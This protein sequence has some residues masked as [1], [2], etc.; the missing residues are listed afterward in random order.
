MPSASQSNWFTNTTVQNRSKLPKL[1]A[2]HIIPSHKSSQPN[3]LRK[4]LQGVKALE[5]TKE[6]ILFS[7]GKKICFKTRSANYKAFISRSDFNEIELPDLPENETDLLGTTYLFLNSKKENLEKGA[8]YTGPKISQLVSEGL[9]FSRGQRVLDPSCGSGSLLLA[10]LAAP[11]SLVGIDNDPNAI[12]CATFNYFAK[13]P[14]A[15]SPSLLTCDFFEWSRSNLDEKFDYILANPP[16]GATLDLERFSN[17]VVESGESFSYF[18][19][20]S[21]HHLKPDGVM[22]FLL[23]EAFMNVKRHKDIRSHLIDS[24]NIQRIKKIPGKFSGVMSDIVLVEMSKKRSSTFLFE[25]KE[26]TKVSFETI[27]AL[28]NKIFV[29]LNPNEDKL[30]RHLAEMD[31]VNL[32]ESVFGLGVVTGNNTKHLLDLPTVDSEPIFTGKNVTPFVLTPPNKHIV[33]RRE[34]LQ[35]VASDSIYRESPKLVYKVVSKRLIFAVDKSRSLTTNSANLVIPKVETHDAYSVAALLNSSLFNFLHLKYAGGVNKVGKENLINL[36]LIRLT[37]SQ[38]EFLSNWA[39]SYSR[40]KDLGELD[41]YI[42]K[43]LLVLPPGLIAAVLKL[44]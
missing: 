37:E 38:R 34:L 14:N 27:Q 30:L 4:F 44:S 7:L 19:E 32:A 24:R 12:L 15:K 5:T 6:Q 3:E 40:D 22:R 33:F 2:L 20:E 41:H 9:D 42:M 28:P 21:F 29:S 26:K 25:D 36:P 43:D 31:T 1:S 16:F 11:E 10:S 35:Q 13:Y 23:P 18:I 17:S 8:F 39:Q